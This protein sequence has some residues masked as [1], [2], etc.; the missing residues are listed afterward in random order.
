MK[1][2]SPLVDAL[3][4]WVG[5]RIADNFEGAKRESGEGAKILR[6]ALRI[7][8]KDI[9]EHGIFGGDNSFFRK[10]LG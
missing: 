3:V 8:W 7:S 6:T 1:K 5:D 4:A 10:P 2:E 9:Q